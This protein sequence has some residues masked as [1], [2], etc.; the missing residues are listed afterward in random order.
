MKQAKI[1]QN[2]FNKKKELTIF[3]LSAAMS[4][5]LLLFSPVIIYMENPSAFMVDFKH[6]AVVMLVLAVI[7][8]P[9]S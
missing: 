1:K 8:F 6:I 4:F 3:A 5:I 9:H 2:V 7:F